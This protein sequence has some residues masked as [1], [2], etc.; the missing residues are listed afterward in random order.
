MKIAIIGLGLI[1][2][3]LGLS[4]KKAEKS[5]EI[6]GIDIEENIIK[7][8]LELG[9][10]DWGTCSIEEGIK[11]ADVV[12]IAASLS[13]TVSIVEKAIPFLK[14]G[15]IISDTGSTKKKISREITDLIKRRNGIFYV[16]GH[17]MAGSEKSGI[18]AAD[19]YLFENAVYVI[20]DGDSDKKAQ[21]VIIELVKKTGARVLLL[22]ADDHDMMVAS[23]SHL[24]HLL[25]GVLVNTVGKIEEI[26]ENVFKIAAGGFR[27][28]TRIADSQ[29]ELWKD[30]FLSNKESLLEVLGIY[31]KQMNE[32]EL[33]I[34]NNQEK[35]LVEKLLKSKK[36]REQVP[37]KVK[38]LLPT[39]SEIV[40]T[41]PDKPGEIGKVANILGAKD[42]N[43]IDIEILRVREG[44][45][46][47]LRLGFI[48]ELEREKAIEVL[49]FFGYATKNI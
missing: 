19:P 23:V 6:I 7:K 46:G 29:P 9:A 3:S 11:D 25:A 21:K 17:P 10:I 2:G 18:E 8:G 13:Q 12:F 47:T 14:P 48:H 4:L 31:K 41:I 5:L 44:D 24:P 22:E 15:A 27:D 26:H 40:V 39:L 33:L 37:K 1:G 43:I 45:G 28:V 34:K 20:L 32:L 16:G 30:I 49:K 38:G 42:I 35:E 36:L